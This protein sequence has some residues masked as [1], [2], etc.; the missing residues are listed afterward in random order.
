MQKPLIILQKARI[1]TYLF[2]LLALMS[3]HLALAE[4]PTLR[5]FEAGSVITAEEMNENLAE[6]TQYIDE[7]QALAALS[8]SDAETLAN[9]VTV[10]EEA[11]LTLENNQLAQANALVSPTSSD[12]EGLLYCIHYYNQGNYQGANSDY[13]SVFLTDYSSEYVFTNTGFSGVIRKYREPVLGF[14][15]PNIETLL[16]N[17][18]FAEAEAPNV[19]VVR[20]VENGY[21]AAD[22]TGEFMPLSTRGLVGWFGGMRGSYDPPALDASLFPQLRIAIACNEDASSLV[23]GGAE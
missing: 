18:S 20:T 1:Y 2:G 5:S 11:Q 16:F 14:R 23:E 12:I 17:S 10:L 3:G 9:E 4:P 15:G 21:N 7:I 6:I 8:Q 13:M 22:F 19:G